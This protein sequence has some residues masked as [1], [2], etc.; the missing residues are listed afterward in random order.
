MFGFEYDPL[1]AP[2][3]GRG[4]MAGLGGNELPNSPNLTANIGAQYVFSFS[5]WDMTVRGDYYWQDASYARIFNTEYDRLKAWDNLNLSVVVE[6]ANKDLV[7][8]A[9][10]KNVFDD[11]PITDVFTNSD[12]TGLTANI[13]TLDPRLV[14]FS[15]SKRF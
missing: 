9:Y 8:T 7:F 10:V 12:D 2:N 1:S 5:G 6:N 15:V 3:G 11:A 13:F 14:A 4:I